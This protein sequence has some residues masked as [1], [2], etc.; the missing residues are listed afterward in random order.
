M[1]VKMAVDF[2]A[3]DFIRSRNK[4]RRAEA[5]KKEKIEKLKKQIEKDMETLS[6]TKKDY[7]NSV[8]DPAIQK[9][10][11]IRWT[12]EINLCAKKIEELKKYE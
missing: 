4:Q 6:K 11:M 2:E 1:G 8:N 10:I 5:I 7:D 9:L 12:N 3:L